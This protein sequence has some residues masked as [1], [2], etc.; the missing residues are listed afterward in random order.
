MASHK[1]VHRINRKTGKDVYEWIRIKS[2]QDHLYD[3][4]TYLAGLAVY[5]RVIAAESAMAQ[6]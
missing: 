4:E 5:G 6:A 2:R 1:K 3:C